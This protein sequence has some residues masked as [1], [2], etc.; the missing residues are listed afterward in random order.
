[1]ARP[2]EFE[3]EAAAE[4]LLNAFWL[5]GFTRTSIPQLTEATGLLPGSLYAAFGSKDNMFRI[6]ADR[7]VKQLRAALAGGARGT[8]GVRHVLDTVVRLTAKDPERRGCLLI[9]AIPESSSLSPETRSRVQRGF[10]EMRG[11]VRER[12]REAR[13]AAKTDETDETDEK[14]TAEDLDQL[15]S[16]V[17]AALVAIR[18]LGRAGQ[19]RRLLQDIADGAMAAVRRSLPPGPPTHHSGG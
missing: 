9:N 16:L 15:A 17:F 5:H 2:R 14:T 13:E 4:G 7:Y 6:A 12:L 8:E 11:F 19:E 10:Q 18:V 3:L 1:M